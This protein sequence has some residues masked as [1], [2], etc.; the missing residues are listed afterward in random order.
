GFLWGACH[1]S[2]ADSVQD[3]VDN[4]LDVVQWGDDG[5]RDAKTLLALDF[6]PSS[7]GRPNMSLSQAHDFVTQINT[8]TG[9]FPVIYGGSL[10]RESVSSTTRYNIL[11]NCQLW[12]ER[13]AHQPIGIRTNTCPSYTL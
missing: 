2:S 3:Q 7:H 5:A 4:F 11:R 12:Y 1:F 13:Y 10:L 8:R 6:E 9:R